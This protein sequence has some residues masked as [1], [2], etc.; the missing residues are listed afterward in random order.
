[1]NYVKIAILIATFAAGWS[2]NGWRIGEDIAAAEAQ[3]ARDTIEI[4][5]LNAEN[6]NEV[7]AR[8]AAE[9]AAQVVKTRTI[10]KEVIKYVQSPDAGQCDLSDDWVRIHND[11]TGVST[12]TETPSRTD[13]TPRESKNDVDALVTITDNYAICQANATKLQAL[14]EWAKSINQQ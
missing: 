5:R 4:E 3:R 10:T 13:D 6:A 8:H 14:Q 12:T 7:A 9:A 1:V 11:S 2:V